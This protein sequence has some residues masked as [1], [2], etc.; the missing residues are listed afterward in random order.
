[1]ESQDGGESI[2]DDIAETQKLLTVV[3][4]PVVRDRLLQ[5]LHA[6]QQVT[7]IYLCHVVSAS[8]VLRW[9]NSQQAAFRQ[10]S[11]MY[12][13]WSVVGVAACTLVLIMMLSINLCARQASR[14]LVLCAPYTIAFGHSRL[15]ALFAKVPVGIALQWLHKHDPVALCC[16]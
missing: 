10:V 6:L 3:T 2:D 12:L 1:M 11:F 16:I 7:A 14:H 8:P 4:R 13:G 9:V 5:L 15:Y